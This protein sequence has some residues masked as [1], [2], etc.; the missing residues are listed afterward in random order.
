MKKV[1]TITSVKEIPTNAMA[2]SE[3]M[4]LKLSGR[5][6]VLSDVINRNS[7]GPTKP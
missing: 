7:A 3:R 2:N 4:E 6:A 1:E 5:T